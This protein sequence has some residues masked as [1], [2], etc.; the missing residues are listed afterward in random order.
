MERYNITIRCI[1]V[2]IFGGIGSFLLLLFA[3]VAFIGGL[4]FVFLLTFLV[5][6]GIMYFILFVTPISITIEGNKICFYRLGRKSIFK[7]SQIKKIDKFY[8]AKSL[9]LSLG[10]R[11]EADMFCV[12]RL[13]NKPFDLL[14]FSHGIRNYKEL[15]SKITQLLQEGGTTLQKPRARGNVEVN[16]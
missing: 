10:N 13:Y 9:F 16:G 5:G 3:T 8:S 6:I 7:V 11:N 14:M 12:I 1:M 15:Y 2:L 4:P